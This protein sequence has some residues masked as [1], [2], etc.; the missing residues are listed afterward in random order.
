MAAEPDRHY[1][2]QPLGPGLWAALHRAD[3]W[4]VGNAGLVDLGGRTLLFDAGM[5]RQAGAELARTARERT[6]RDVDWLVLSHYH[7]DHVRGAQALPAATVVTSAATARLLA[8]KGRDELEGDREGSEDG[9]AHALAALASHDLRERRMGAFL[10]PYYEGLVASLPGTELPEPN[11]TFEREATFVGSVRRAV[12]RTL[13]PGHTPDDA[14]LILPDDGVAFCSDLL[15]VGMHPFLPNGDPDGWRRALTH[16]ADLD[17]DTYV[18]GHGPPVGRDGLEAFGAYLDGL[19][20]HAESLARDGVA[21][22]ELDDAWPDD[23]SAD[24][25]LVLPFYRA[26]LRFL[27]ERHRN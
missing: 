2:L 16:L 4:G 21:P 6:G 25:D 14:V 18:P 20:A 27:V 26:N 23:A 8:T 22:S 17:V 7:N 5:T 11:V 13:G 19:R 12:V 9:L 15:F 24:W 1:D 10:R 3:G